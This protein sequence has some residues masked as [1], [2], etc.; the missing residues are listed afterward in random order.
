MNRKRATIVFYII[1]AIGSSGI[2]FSS[3]KEKPMDGMIIFTEVP[4]KLK[5]INYVTG[6]SWRYVPHV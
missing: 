3:C 5:D 1:M 6:N 4:G 2:L